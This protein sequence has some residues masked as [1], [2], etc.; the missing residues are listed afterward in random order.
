M[1]P[2]SYFR[3]IYD[4]SALDTRFTTPASVPYR[5]AQETR[6]DPAVAKDHAA[7]IKASAAPSRWTSPEYIGYAIFLAWAIP[8]MFVIGYNVS[9]R[10]M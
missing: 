10:M 3:S 1:G 9:K 4:V 2:F 7:S 5:T 6:D 8:G